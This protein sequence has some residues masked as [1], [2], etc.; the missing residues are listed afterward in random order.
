MGQGDR[1][2]SYA[3]FSPFHEIA[4]QRDRFK[5][6]FDGHVSGLP[7]FYGVVVR[8]AFALQYP[9]LVV[10]YLQAMLAAQ[11]WQHHTA[12]SLDLIG[13]WSQTNLEIL[14]NLLGNFVNPSMYLLDTTLRTDWLQAH[15]EKH[16][17]I[18]GTE[19]IGDIELNDWIRAEYLEK[20][21]LA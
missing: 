4:L 5:Y 1:V 10:S 20:A 21:R 12:S 3:H 2:A 7:S 16:E 6:L 11:Y 15:V 13:N 19:T 9:E 17:A 18:P 14:S 8:E